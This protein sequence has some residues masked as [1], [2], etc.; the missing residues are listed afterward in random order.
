MREGIGRAPWVEEIRPDRAPEDADGALKLVRDDDPLRRG[1]GRERDGAV[2]RDTAVLDRDAFPDP[3]LGVAHERV[4]LELGA[5]G[6]GER[7]RTTAASAVRNLMAVS[8][9]RAYGR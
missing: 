5:C 9:G 2:A 1:V 4:E 6:D 3:H 7:S 8:F